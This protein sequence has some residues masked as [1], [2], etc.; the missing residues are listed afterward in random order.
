MASPRRRTA[1]LLPTALLLAA[2]SLAAVA[3]ATSGQL[4]VGRRSEFKHGRKLVEDPLTLPW[5][6]E[7]TAHLPYIGQEASLDR[8]LATQARRGW[9]LLLPFA[10]GQEE[11]ALNAVASYMQFGK[12]ANFIAHSFDNQSLE[13]CKQLHLP[14]FDAIKLRNGRLIA[15]R[16]AGEGS[17]ERRPATDC[18]LLTPGPRRGSAHARRWRMGRPG[19][20][21]R[22]PLQER[23]DAG[24]LQGQHAP[25]GA[26]QGL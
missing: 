5:L 1:A 13:R 3:E 23:A 24:L 20:L 14:C 7:S 26:E 2:L 11:L 10:S 22:A 21:P 4:H 25:S 19:R 17:D 15:A 16:A 8:L 12:A 6:L 18:T 9:V